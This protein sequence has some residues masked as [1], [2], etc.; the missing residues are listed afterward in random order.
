[1]NRSYWRM[2]E[3]LGHRERLSTKIKLCLIR[4]GT[5]PFTKHI[6]VTDST[7]TRGLAKGERTQPPRAE[8]HQPCPYPHL[9][10]GSTSPSAQQFQNMFQQVLCQQGDHPIEYMDSAEILPLTVK[11]AF[12]VLELLGMIGSMC[13]VMRHSAII[14]WSQYSRAF[15]IVLISPQLEWATKVKEI[16][17]VCFVN[18]WEDAQ[19]TWTQGHW[20]W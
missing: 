16:F 4:H 8:T 1:M 19:G 10:S 9:E 17:V 13:G 18:M 15:I 14:S 2:G 5:S 7:R 6:T 20:C 11:Q 3:D 12:Y